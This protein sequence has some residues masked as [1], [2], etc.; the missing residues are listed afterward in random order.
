MVRRRVNG[1]KE[2]NMLGQGVSC[3]NHLEEVGSWLHG[4]VR[5]GFA[6]HPWERDSR[7]IDST[8]K[9]RDMASSVSSFLI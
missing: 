5:Q 7:Q 2:I 3:D 6:R 4:S 8:Q 9:F 1:I